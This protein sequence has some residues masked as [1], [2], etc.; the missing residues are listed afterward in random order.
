[1]TKDK[2]K[3]LISFNGMEENWLEWSL[4]LKAVESQK[5]W[6]KEMNNPDPLDHKSLDKNMKERIKK[7]SEAWLYCR[8]AIRSTLEK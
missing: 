3:Y 7:N 6:W 1:M 5:G 8:V 2:D 4:K